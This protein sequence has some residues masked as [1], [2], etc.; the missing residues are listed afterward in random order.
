MSAMVAALTPLVAAMLSTDGL[1]PPPPRTPV[2][3]GERWRDV[4]PGP[5]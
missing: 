1:I 2:A 5:L 3:I 4:P